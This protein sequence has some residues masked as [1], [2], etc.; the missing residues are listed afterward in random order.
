MITGSAKSP[1]H[2]TTSKNLWFCHACEE[3]GNVIDL[4]VEMEE[5]SAKAAAL[6]LA[7]WF[8]IETTSKPQGD[9]RRRRRRREGTKAAD[10]TVSAETEAVGASLSDDLEEGHRVASPGQPDS[11]EEQSA[12]QAEAS[13]NPPLTFELKNLDP[14]HELLKPLG[15]NQAT[16][17]H[18]EAGFCARGMM[19]GRLAVPIHSPAGELLAYAGR[20]LADDESYKYP[21]S[22]SRDLELYNLHRA[23]Q[24]SHLGAVG[25]VVVPEI[26]D[27]W[28]CFEAGYPNAV[29]LM[30][31]T[32]SDRQQVLLS[33]LSRPGTRLVTLLLPPG[34]ERDQIFTRLVCE[35]W[36]RLASWQAAPHTMQ[37]DELAR[38]LA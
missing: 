22:F 23:R 19:A 4:V 33:S 10:A 16:I 38:V 7:E 37:T 14:G 30:A 29:A 20:G 32:M 6:K 3:G 9:G 11:E 21:E 12:G 25:L 34:Q 27:V 1:F 15:F 13:T 18:F 8:G 17:E 31:T 5:C 28:C 2:I 26:L 36:V 35:L 24:V